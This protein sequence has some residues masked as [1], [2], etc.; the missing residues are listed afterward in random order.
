MTKESSLEIMLSLVAFF[1]LV[2]SWFVL[3]ASPE[4]ARLPEAALPDA[5]RSAA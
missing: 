5:L 4:P 3:P 2:L 1:A